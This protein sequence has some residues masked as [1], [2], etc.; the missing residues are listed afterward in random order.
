MKVP[1]IA[2]PYLSQWQVRLWQVTYLPHLSLSQ[3]QAII[4][5][6]GINGSP[7]AGKGGNKIIACGWHS[8][9]LG[10]IDS[11]AIDLLVSPILRYC[12]NLRKF[13]IFIN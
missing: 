7:A 9:V 10:L 5:R 12:Y 2:V 3:P 8:W 4:Y 13:M 6:K 1:K 11:E